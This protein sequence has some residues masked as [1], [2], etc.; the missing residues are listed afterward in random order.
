M[1]SGPVKIHQISA[2]FRSIQTPIGLVVDTLEIEAEN[3]EIES[4]PF[5]VRLK[6]AG[7]WKAR[8]EEGAVQM[9]LEQKAPA[10]LQN[11]QATLLEGQVRVT[12]SVRVLIEL[13]VEALS[14]LEIRDGRQLWVA[15][16]SVQVAGV[17]GKSLVEKQIEKI[18]PILDV[19]ELPFDLRMN[20]VTIL[21]GEIWVE[22]TVSP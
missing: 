7:S 13:S 14:H 6:K 3:A 2:T 15:L 9:L 11:V 5:E 16:D 22:G 21:P 19:N 20:S 12:G 4:D 8:V 18:N 1:D 17:G 10:E